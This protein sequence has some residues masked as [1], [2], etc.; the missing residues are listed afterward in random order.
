[1]IARMQQTI[2][3]TKLQLFKSTMGEPY[4][5]RLRVWLKAFA[6]PYQAVRQEVES[7][8]RLPFIPQQLIVHGLVYELESGKVD[9]VV[10]GYDV[11]GQAN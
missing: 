4:P 8:K 7:I 6:D 11:L 2:D 5:E 1:M 3:Q 9:V 10:N